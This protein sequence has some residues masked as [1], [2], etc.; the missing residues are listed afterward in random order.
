[1]D[2]FVPLAVL[3]KLTVHGFIE[4]HN[5]MEIMVSSWVLQKIHEGVS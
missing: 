1:M 5:N 3:R 2:C 4:P